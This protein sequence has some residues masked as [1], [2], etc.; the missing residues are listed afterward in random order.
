M[1]SSSVLESMRIS[2]QVVS[3]STLNLPTDRVRLAGFDRS[4][5]YGRSTALTSAVTL[6]MSAGLTGLRRRGARPMVLW[7]YN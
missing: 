3:G 1:S 5:E 7:R 2:A 4:D 6:T